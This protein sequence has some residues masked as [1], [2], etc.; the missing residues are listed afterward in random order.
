LTPA[1]WNRKRRE[2]MGALSSSPISACNHYTHP[3]T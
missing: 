3:K 1:N 2:R